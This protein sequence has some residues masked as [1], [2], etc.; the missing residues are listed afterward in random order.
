[1]DPVDAAAAVLLHAATAAARLAQDA[2]MTAEGR[3]K[4]IDKP[5]PSA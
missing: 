4:A 2:A 3:R 1:M 5:R